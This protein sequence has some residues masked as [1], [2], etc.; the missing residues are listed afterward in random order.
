[1]LRHI[2][3]RVLILIP[4]LLAVSFAV[5]IMLRL[6]PGDPVEIIVGT[7][8]SAERREQVRQ[9][10]RL[11]E[12]I[13]VQYGSFLTRAVRGDFGRSYVL[14][15]TVTELIGE[16]LGNSLRLGV[17]ALALSYLLAVPLGVLVAARHRTWVD[18]AV[19]WV[20]A[21]GIAVPGFLIGLAF[22]YVFAYK[23]G[24]FPTSGYGTTRHLI[25]PVAALT[26]E[27]LALTVRFVRTA[28]LEELSSDYVRT[29]R[30]KG[31]STRRVLWGHALRNALLP[32]ISLLALRIGWLVGGTVVIEVVFAWPGA[33]RFLVD[34]VVSRD[35]PVVQALTLVL[36]A[37]VVV[38]SLLADILYAVVNPR[39]RY[40]S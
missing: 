37:A 2:A 18:Y 26:L 33:G 5:F 32:L 25:L 23:F 11:D 16:R 28:M 17:P 12:P 38:S 8:A 3:M 1:V 34:S 14:G 6:V 24:W 20:S 22:I 39:I 7:Q 40:S 13:L 21:L 19:N 27:G 36:A 9:E 31:L 30:S 29:A 15:K 10:L 35:Y 4:V